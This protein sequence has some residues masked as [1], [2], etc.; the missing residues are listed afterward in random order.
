[1]STN[2]DTYE[3]N[4]QYASIRTCTYTYILFRHKTLVKMCFFAS[5]TITVTYI[6]IVKTSD[7]T[8]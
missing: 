8:P 6:I 2:C 4:Q 3:L 7:S 1:M 5:Y